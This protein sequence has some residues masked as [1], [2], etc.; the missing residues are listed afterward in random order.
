MGNVESVGL[1]K[2]DILGL[3][4]L[5]K[6]M[7]VNEL[8]KHLKSNKYDFIVLLGDIL[9]TFEQT[10]QQSFGRASKLLIELNEIIKT[11][12]IIGNHDRPNNNIFLTDEHFFNSFKKYKN[13]KIV[14]IPI[15]E[16]NYLFVPYV[17]PGRFKE[18]IKDFEWENVNCI[19]AH[20]EIKG[21]KLGCLISEEGDLWEED[22][23]PIISGH[24]HEFHIPQK[25][26]FYCPTPFQHGF[27]DNT[28]KFICNFNLSNS[29]EYLEIDKL[30]SKSSLE[31]D[32][33][34]YK[35]IKL[36]IKKKRQINLSLDEFKKYEKN[37][38]YITKVVIEGSTFLI[39]EYLKS[40]NICND[41]YTKIQIK[42][43]N[44]INKSVNYQSFEKCNN[45]KER[46]LEEIKKEDEGV[47]TEY[48]KLFK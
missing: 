14:D 43:T 13:I 21:C 18:A 47:M 41:E 45:Y 38:N 16:N 1:I 3:A 5:D 36:Q 29:K 30:N 19:F 8:L 9:D 2:F 37:E 12:L 26:V 34:K 33:F 28:E 11:Y 27:T 15:L 46:L 35:K 17:A 24:I 39:K 23:P 48:K 10:H 20:Q 44:N 22:N 31:F 4:V 40:K 42:E 7:A 32:K 6:L 25:N